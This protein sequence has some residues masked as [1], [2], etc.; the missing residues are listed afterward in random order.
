[1]TVFQA[2]VLGIVQGVT[3]FLPVSSSGHLIVFPELLGWDVSSVTFDVAIHVATLGA[4]CV[5]L[6]DDIMKADRTLIKNVV[7]ATLPAVLVGA[8][9]HDFLE[10]FRTM[11]VVGFSLILWGVVL[12]FAEFWSKQL[13]RHVHDPSKMTLSQSMIIGIAQVLAFIPGTSRSGVTMSTGLFTGLD[14][15]AAAKFSFFLAIPAI[16]GAG[17]LTTLDVMKHGLDVPVTP[18][19]A[20]F[21]AA[22]ISGI[23]AI[24]FLF[25]IIKQWS[26]VPFA[27]YR[28]L[29]GLILLWIALT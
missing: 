23:L 25:M 24:K 1:M 16:A 5:A 20:G 10:G 26:F 13:G 12:L 22:F 19:F 18:L 7:L 28:V 17:A 27:I 6:K 29:F 21:I 11:A 4:I 2:V 15:S 3:E 9:L 14:K 8:L